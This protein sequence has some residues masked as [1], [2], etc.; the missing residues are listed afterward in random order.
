MSAKEIQKKYKGQLQVLTK[1][2][3]KKKGA[4]KQAAEEKYAALEAEMEEELAKLT[5]GGDGDKKATSEAKEEERPQVLKKVKIDWDKKDIAGYSKSELSAECIKL[6]LSKKGGKEDLVTRLMTFSLD[7]DQRESD[8]EEEE[9]EET[10]TEEEKKEAARMYKREQA[11][12]K[13]LRV[14]LKKNPDGVEVPDV[15]T[16][17]A[18][19]GV[20]NFK[21]QM[22]GYEQMETLLKEMPEFVLAYVEGD[23]DSIM[24][25][26][27][28]I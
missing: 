16:K 14:L 11:I 7:N 9:E 10:M 22:L 27:V 4:Y 28:D 20:K 26:E 17:L 2:I 18:E 8:E 5:I 19:L 1:E 15:A 3:K 24:P 23:P 6:G 21:P 25:A 13:A 12:Q